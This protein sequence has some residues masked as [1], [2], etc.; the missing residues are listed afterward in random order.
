MVGKPNLALQQVIRRISEGHYVG[1][2]KHVHVNDCITVKKLHTYGPVP[3]QYQAFRQ[4]KELHFSD[5]Y[6]S[7]NQGDNCI[8]IGDS[9]GLVRN[10]LS[11]NEGTEKLI[12]YEKFGT[13]R[14]V[15]TYPLQSMDLRVTK[16]SNLSGHLHVASA[17][18]VTC[19]FFF[20]FTTSMLCSL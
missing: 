13:T 12:L 1:A 2:F 15:F 17:T 7:V 3:R 4:Y 11:D 20:R 14:N 16:V 19:V 9:V 8:L 18:S 5:Y 10:I 6:I